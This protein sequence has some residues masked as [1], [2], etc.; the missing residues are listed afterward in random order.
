M[1]APNV[2]GSDGFGKRFLNLD[3]RPLRVDAVKDLRDSAEWV[4]K[5]GVG[6]PRR[7]GVMGGSYGGYMVMAGLT[8][9]PGCSP[10]EPTSSES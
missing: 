9:F 3:N 2:R 8:E 5:A 6:D 4:V 10:Q 1:F 7:L